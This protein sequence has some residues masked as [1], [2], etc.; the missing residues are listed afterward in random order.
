MIQHA[1]AKRAGHEFIISTSVRCPGPGGL[2][3]PVLHMQH[4]IPQLTNV[5][6]NSPR[7]GIMLFSFQASFQKQNYSFLRDN[8][9]SRLEHR[10]RVR[11]KFH[12]AQLIRIGLESI[13]TLVPFSQPVTHGRH[14]GRPASKRKPENGHRTSDVKW[15]WWC[16]CLSCLHRPLP[17]NTVTGQ[18]LSRSRRPNGNYRTDSDA[19]CLGASLPKAGERLFLSVPICPSI[20]KDGLSIEE[21]ICFRNIQVP[22]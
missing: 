2:S 15:V 7:K 20:T 16:L 13:L 11:C 17:T 5:V 10:D 4:M 9:F 8:R 3:H 19:A 21:N 18:I 6:K 22:N 14:W 1:A 12:Q